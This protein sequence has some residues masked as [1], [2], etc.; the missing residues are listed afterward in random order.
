MKIKKIVVTSGY[1]NPIHIGHINLM[2]EAKKIGDFLVVIVNNDEQVKVKG[3]FPF[4]PEQERVEI[5]KALSFVD[6]V[7]LSADSDKAVSK[8]LE[9]IFQRYNDKKL[10]FAKGGD[11][12]M[13]NVPELSICEKYNANLILAVGGN[14]VQSSSWLIEKSRQRTKKA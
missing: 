7:V 2:R 14:K 5:V 11:S 12:T 6:E 1:Y 3:S 13:E 4:M 9:Q 8:T 10:F